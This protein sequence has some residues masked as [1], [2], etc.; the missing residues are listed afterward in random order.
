[1]SHRCYYTNADVGTAANMLAI[2]VN[3][4]CSKLRYM[5]TESNIAQ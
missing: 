4:V 5:Y 3:F 2:V 1:M